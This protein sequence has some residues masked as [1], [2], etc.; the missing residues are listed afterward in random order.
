MYFA[1]KPRSFLKK[2]QFYF[3]A[4]F[5]ITQQVMCSPGSAYPLSHLLS[6]RLHTAPGR[7]APCRGL[8]HLPELSKFKTDN[9][10]PD[11][12]TWKSKEKFCIK[13]KIRQI[14]AVHLA[15]RSLVRIEVRAIMPVPLGQAKE[16]WSILWFVMDLRNFRC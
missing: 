6:S 11:R 15:S 8:K 10:R 9:R 2:S 7:T 14:T 1:W 16:M 13:E 3:M 4:A 5:R 12:P